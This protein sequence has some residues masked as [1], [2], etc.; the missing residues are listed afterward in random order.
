[1]ICFVF[2]SSQNNVAFIINFMIPTRFENSL[3]SFL[4]VGFYFNSIS[5]KGIFKRFL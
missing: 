4:N 2:F 5:D 3:A 1:M